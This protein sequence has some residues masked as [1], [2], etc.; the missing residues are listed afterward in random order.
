MTRNVRVGLI[1]LGVGVM[2]GFGISRLISVGSLR[3]KLESELSAALGR[4]VK[5]G[6]LSLSL[7][8]REVRADNIS[9][10]DDPALS[11]DAFVTVR[12]LSAS[13][14]L[15]PLILR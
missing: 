3:P 10:A 4:R 11:K 6:G 7:W 2:V 13:V 8:A 5:V 1:A 12:S 14:K 15:R 9:I